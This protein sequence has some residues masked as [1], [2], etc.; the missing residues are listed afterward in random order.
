M[1]EA[2]VSRYQALNAVAAH[3]GCIVDLCNRRKHPED[4]I[5]DLHRTA[6]LAH[7]AAKELSPNRRIT[8][9]IETIVISTRSRN[10]NSPGLSKR[11]KG[12]AMELHGKV[13]ILRGDPPDPTW[14]QGKLL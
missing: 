8:T 4:H 14:K 3:L 9:G 1:T 11:I 13:K 7:Q 10:A 2:E 5:N 6:I 12:M